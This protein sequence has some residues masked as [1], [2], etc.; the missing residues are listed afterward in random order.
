MS[1]NIFIGFS[2]KYIKK[3]YNYKY[4]NLFKALY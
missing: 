1:S 2:F 4:Y 3:F